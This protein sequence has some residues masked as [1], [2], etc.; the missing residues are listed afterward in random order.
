[1]ATARRKATAKAKKPEMLELLS[2]GM[3]K[4]KIAKKLGVSVASV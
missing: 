1:M 4:P 2:T 3:S